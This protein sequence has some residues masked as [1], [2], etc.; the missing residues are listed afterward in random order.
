RMAYAVQPQTPG[1]K[2]SGV[3]DVET[4]SAIWPV[5][6]MNRFNFSSMSPDGMRLIGSRQGVLTIYD[7]S[8]GPATGA[9]L[10]IL[11]LSANQSATHP[12]WSADGKSIVYARSDQ[13]PTDTFDWDIVQASIVTTQY[14]GG[15]FSGQQTIV[16]S[17]NGD[18]NYYPSF[19][20]DGK[21][22]LFNH[23]AGSA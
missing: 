12:D 14:S 21:W 20:P 3:L 17:K 2:W 11:T 23:A 22:I 5:A 6:P 9:V 15:R 7:I 16:A 19:S 18:N 1:D 10:Q 13:P 4:K 8:G